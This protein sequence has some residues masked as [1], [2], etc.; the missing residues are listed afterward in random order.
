M[1]NYVYENK[2]TQAFYAMAWI[3]FVISLLGMISALIYLEADVAIKGFIIISYLFSVSSCFTVAK[4]I[5]DRH[6][7]NKLIT[8]VETAKTERFLNEHSTV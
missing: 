5:R 3:G 6:E 4:V 1:S 8:R 2:N 7:A